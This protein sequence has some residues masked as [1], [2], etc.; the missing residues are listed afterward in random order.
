MDCKMDCTKVVR[1]FISSCKD[2][3]MVIK[4]IT[5]DFDTFHRL[6]AEAKT[7]IGNDETASVLEYNIM[8][9]KITKEDK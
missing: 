5:V 3:M 7:L 2:N 1:E 6:D 9:V 4:E 8:G